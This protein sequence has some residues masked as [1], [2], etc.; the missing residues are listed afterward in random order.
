MTQCFLEGLLLWHAMDAEVMCVALITAQLKD[1]TTSV[2]TV[3]ARV[4]GKENALVADA[5]RS[6][7]GSFH[8][9]VMQRPEFRVDESDNIRLVAAQSPIWHQAI[10]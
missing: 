9:F 1:G 2:A 8:A 3:G 6:S 5:I 10:H 4:F 7:R